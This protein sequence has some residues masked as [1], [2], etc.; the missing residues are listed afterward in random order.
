MNS[1]QAQVQS[2]KV[3]S[4][5]VKTKGTWADTKITWAQNDPLNSPSQKNLP[6]GQQDQGRGV[7]LHFQEEVY[8]SNLTFTSEQCL[9]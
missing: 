9:F 8:Q 6:G 5:K 1:C 4:P 3:Q 2:P 7:V